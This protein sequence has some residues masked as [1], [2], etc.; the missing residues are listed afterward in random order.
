M[1]SPSGRIR[2]P[3]IA[4]SMLP[5]WPLRRCL[6]NSCPPSSD[7]SVTAPEMNPHNAPPLNPSTTISGTD[8]DR[9]SLTT[10]TQCCFAHIG[11]N[12]PIVTP[13][14][15]DTIPPMTPTWN[16][17][18]SFFPSH[19]VRVFLPSWIICA[20]R[21]NIPLNPTPPK[22]PRLMAIAIRSRNSITLTR[23]RAIFVDATAV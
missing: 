8:S 15:A 2:F 14:P 4:E 9:P 10:V 22:D 7:A 20:I 12:V 19:L 3:S 18:S 6:K 13:I 17:V 1:R 11:L 16:A 21:S 23:V 5:F